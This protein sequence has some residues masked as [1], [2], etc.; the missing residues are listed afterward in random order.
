M[1]YG[2][3]LHQA[4]GYTWHGLNM[5]RSVT[6]GNAQGPHVVWG[7]RPIWL[8]APQGPHTVWLLLQ[9]QLSLGVV[10][11]APPRTAT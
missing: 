8:G 9:M 11:A 3:E 6:H 7:T 2:Q 4:K 10:A 5:E 1:F